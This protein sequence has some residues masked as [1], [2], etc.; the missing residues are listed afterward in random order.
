M[1]KEDEGLKFN[2]EMQIEKD[3]FHSV[4]LGSVTSS[5]NSERE[6]KALIRHRKE[7]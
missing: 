2:C 7:V 3:N 1:S 6:N 4:S 5:D